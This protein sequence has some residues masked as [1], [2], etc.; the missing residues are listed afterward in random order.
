MV[1]GSTK[2]RYR[3]KRNRSKKLKGGSGADDEFDGFGNNIYQN[4]EAKQAEQ[5]EAKRVAQE[6]VARAAELEAASREL[7]AKVDA[8]KKAK[9]KEIEEYCETKS[10]EECIMLKIVEKM[11][12]ISDLDI[13]FP[14]P[15]NKDRN[16][17]NGALN[18]LKEE[19]DTLIAEEIQK[20]KAKAEAESKDKVEAETDAAIQHILRE[21]TD[22]ELKRLK[23][24]AEEKAQKELQELKRQTK[25]LETAKVEIK[26]L[27]SLRARLI[28]EIKELIDIES[29][30]GT[31]IDFAQ[32]QR[33]IETE[34]RA[35]R[36][37]KARLDKAVRDLTAEID[38][39]KK[40]DGELSSLKSKK[41]GL[42][43][44]VKSL[45]DEIGELSKAQTDLA[46]TE[47]K[48]TQAQNELA[49]LKLEKET[50]EVFLETIWYRILQKILLNKKQESLSLDQTAK[51]A[52]EVELRFGNARI[53]Q[54]R[55]NSLRVLLKTILTPEAQ[56]F[57]NLKDP[58]KESTVD[59]FIDKIKTK[60]LAL[61]NLCGAPA[62][63]KGGA[64]NTKKKRRRRIRS[65]L[66]R[67][68]N[69]NQS[70]NKKN[71]KSSIKRNKN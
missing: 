61:K 13:G 29:E 31:E 53:N 48:L 2:K 35:L 30:E 65:K 59:D 67:K 19:L 34:L 69:N 20:A 5:E 36:D 24:E 44:E 15:T 14:V 21:L 60:D 32:I 42:D 9:A 1:K 64:R 33:D 68:V 71:K 54:A 38:R 37:K 4:E 62:A 70:S 11:N 43:R 46:D 10:P 63:A 50:L 28:A 56:K 41:E 26:S 51:C 8:A 25:F 22:K 12:E 55:W 66:V 6:K 57:I 17:L 40:V 16:E 27:T 49:E 23:R 3:V 18:K 45:T 47:T 39:I 52:K 7:Q 58:C